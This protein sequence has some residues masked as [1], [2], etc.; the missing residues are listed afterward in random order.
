MQYPFHGSQA[1]TFGCY[2]S[3]SLSVFQSIKHASV[4]KM[5]AFAIQQGY[6]I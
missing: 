3:N 1:L 6:W 4:C 5:V 2:P